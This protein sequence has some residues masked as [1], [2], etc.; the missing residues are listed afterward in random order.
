MASSNIYFKPRKLDDEA[1][2]KTIVSNYDTEVKRR[3]R[4]IDDEYREDLNRHVQAGQFQYS[5]LSMHDVWEKE[6]L[7][8]FGTFI[9]RESNWVCPRCGLEHVS[10]YPPL[11]C[12]RCGQIS[13]LGQYVNMKYYKR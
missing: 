11:K 9:P 3:R 2:E 7:D 5:L 6:Y 13:P 10:G 8:R 12:G 4:S 1:L